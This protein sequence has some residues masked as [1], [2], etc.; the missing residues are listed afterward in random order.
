MEQSLGKRIMQYR[1]R[2]GLTQ[3][4]LAEQLGVTAQAVSKWE[5]DQSCPDI[6]S[7]PRL[8]DIFG[9]S[10]DVLLG[11]ETTPPQTVEVIDEP[12]V[13]DAPSQKTPQL[14]FSWDSD[15]TDT[16]GLALAVLAVGVLYFL[17][18][19][20]QWQVGFWDLAW[21]T[22]LLVFGLWQ[23]RKFSFFR[24]GCAL[25]GG[26]SLLVNLSVI[27][28][29]PDSGILIAIGIVLF[30]LSLLADALRKK[31]QSTFHI[32]QNDGNNPGENKFSVEGDSFTFH[33]SF[34]QSTQCVCMDRFRF[35]EIHTSFGD[36]N[37]DLSG[38]EEVD[39]KNRLEI[40]VSFGDLTLHVPR[41]YRVDPVSSTAFAGFEIS[42]YP[43][44]TPAAVIHMD[45]HVSFGEIT[46]QYI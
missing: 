23:F 17:S 43:N 19:L 45:A 4:Q 29:L 12:A 46:V 15:K 25:F 27:P 34:S 21:P 2:L 41:Q 6:S 30:G 44:P 22:A 9:T 32:S 28:D 33:S 13:E 26:Y 11:R 24:L 5:N 3:D 18:Q 31:K 35:G 40:H 38:I 16:I 1:K 37:V 36:Y 8:A 42:G 10:V 39:A 20:L 14:S 7:L